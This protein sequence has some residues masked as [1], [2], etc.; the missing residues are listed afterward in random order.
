MQ[1]VINISKKMY[2]ECKR[3]GDSRDE[4]FEAIRNGTSLPKGHGRLIDA[5]ELSVALDK[6]A[7]MDSQPRAIRRCIRR[8]KEEPTIIQASES[9][10]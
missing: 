9:E 1:I 2:E 10:G 5:D 8:I 4:L 6:M 7:Y 3:L